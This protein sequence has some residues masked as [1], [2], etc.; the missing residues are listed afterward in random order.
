M[1]DAAHR[2]ARA[3]GVSAH[4]NIANGLQ[5]YERVWNWDPW[6]DTF[7]FILT[8]VYSLRTNL[9]RDRKIQRR[10]KHNFWSSFNYMIRSQNQSEAIQL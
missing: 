7:T 4:P 5:R 8:S 3:T 9:I 6:G 2:T 10:E 1:R